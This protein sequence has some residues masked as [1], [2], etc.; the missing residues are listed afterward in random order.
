MSRCRHGTPARTEN[1]R[2]GPDGMISGEAGVDMDEVIA[3]AVLIVAVL[4]LE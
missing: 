1:G 2:C 4:F 3:W